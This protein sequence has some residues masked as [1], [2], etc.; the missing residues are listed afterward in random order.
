MGLESSF[1]M[2][3]YPKFIEYCNYNALPNELTYAQILYRLG[4][5]SVETI[6]E[7]QSTKF[8]LS[9]NEF[10]LFVLRWGS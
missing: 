7:K 3:D 5:K 2:L 6:S 10:M 1:S 9:S 8:I 4:Y